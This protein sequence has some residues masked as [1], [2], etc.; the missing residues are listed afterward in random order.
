MPRTYTHTRTVADTRALVEH[1]T[2]RGMR[3]GLA[4][5]PGNTNLQ[6]FVET[7]RA[8]PSISLALVMTV[9]PGFGGQPFREEQMDKVRTLR[10]A[11]PE[12]DIQVDGGLDSKTVLSAAAAGANVIVAG[13]S[14]FRAVDAAGVISTL[15]SA[16]S[17][18]GSAAAGAATAA[19][20]TASLAASASGMPM[21]QLKLVYFNIHGLAARIRIACAVG[22]VQ[23][24]DYR[25]S[26]RDEF[27]AMKTSGELPFGQVPLLEIVQASGAPPV[28]LAQSC[29]ILKFV[30]TL[31]G[32]YPAAD[33]VVSA[34]ID[35]QVASCTD[36]MSSYGALNYAARNGLAHL[37]EDAVAAGFEAQR[38]DV[39]PRHL[40][41]L[42]AALGGSATGWVNGT[43][44]PS[45]ADFAWGTQL[46][47]IRAGLNE[48]KLPGA[49]LDAF[50]RTL[51]FLEKFLR[52]AEVAAYYKTWP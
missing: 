11:F 14:V 5:R 50:P 26:S 17:G 37:S 45:C 52:L 9:E 29:A 49:V 19:T 46:R 2:A 51:L 41:Y 13:T 31:G 25:F 27:L 1:I 28:K 36:M 23:F 6:A 3:A 43:A 47:D 30:C 48:P 33:P 24:D 16:V 34:A 10:A 35:A 18:V 4:I 32:L 20:A 40:G 38:V 12:L 42:E 8:V 21:P 7:L 44:K 39:I 22:G 15:R